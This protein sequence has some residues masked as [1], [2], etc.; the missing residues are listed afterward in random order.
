[1]DTRWLHPFTAIL[2]G[3]SKSG[4]SYFVSRFLANL[5]DMC[6][7]EFD[8]ILF[9]YGEWQEFYRGLAGPIE[10]REGLPQAEDYSRDNKKPS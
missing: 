4:K 7:V 3:P 6:T 5:R 2:A 9:Y 10:F 1:M 8:R